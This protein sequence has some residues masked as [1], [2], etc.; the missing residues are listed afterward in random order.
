MGADGSG[1]GDAVDAVRGRV[2]GVGSLSGER[3]PGVSEGAGRGVLRGEDSA[4]GQ[5]AEVEGVR[6]E[7]VQFD[8]PVETGQGEC[9]VRGG[10]GE[11][12]AGGGGGSAADGRGAG[13]GRWAVEAAG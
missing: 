4:T 2:A 13:S 6:V 1:H 8:E 10:V 3:A 5:L 12:D 11:G 7:G 9:G